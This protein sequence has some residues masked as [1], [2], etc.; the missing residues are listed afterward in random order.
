M[1]VVFLR[2]YDFP[3]GGAPQNRLLGICRGLINEGIEVEVHQYGPS[4]LG[5]PLNLLPQQTY[6]SV[7]IFNH[8]WRWSPAKNKLHQVFGLLIGYLSTITALIKSH[9]HSHIDFIFINAEINSYLLPFFIL[10]RLFGAKLGRDL[11]EY[12]RFILNPG[13]YRNLNVK[14][15]MHTNYK[16]FDVLFIITGFLRDYYLKL[17]KKNVKV[18]LLPMTVDIDR[19]PKPAESFIESDY[20]TY[21]GDVSQSKDGVITLIESFALLKDEYPDLKLKLIGSNKDKDYMEILKQ[22]IA[23]SGVTE[24]V[25][26]TGFVNP[27]NIPDELYKSRLLV[28]SRPANIQAKG[29]F[30]TKLGEYLATG[31]PVVVTSVGEL[32][33]YLKDEE[34]AFM[35]EPDNVVSFADAM[36][37][38]LK[39]IPL[40][41]SVGHN[42]RETALKHFSH[43]E[44]G[45]LISAFLKIE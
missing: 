7:Q 26:F 23:Q 12:P 40:S 32:P 34:N 15:K 28:L 38:S 5:L 13:A 25:V 10:S 16:W 11:N 17:A 37:R 41:K 6:K 1:K 20:I 30:P 36:K 31:I 35:A 2:A 9:R 19:F 39:N 8:A 45:K 42:G 24:R 4:K 43:I 29:G 14:Y 33:M 44:Q 22:K 21:C 18:L 27:E 3:L